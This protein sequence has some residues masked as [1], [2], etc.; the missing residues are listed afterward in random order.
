MYPRLSTAIHEYGMYVYV[1]FFRSF[2]KIS[3]CNFLHTDHVH[4][5]S[6][7]LNISFFWIDYKWW[8]QFWFPHVRC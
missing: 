6:V 2:L 4:I 5:L 1:R 7:Y 8:F 3:I